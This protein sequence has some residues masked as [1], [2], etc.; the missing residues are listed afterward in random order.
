MRLLR[1]LSILTRHN[2]EAFS[3]VQAGIINDNSVP[4][5][6]SLQIYAFQLRRSINC[7]SNLEKKLNQK[8][9]NADVRH[10]LVIGPGPVHSSQNLILD[11]TSAQLTYPRST[12]LP[13]AISSPYKKAV[14]QPG[15]ESRA[16]ESWSGVNV[17]QW[18]NVWYVVFPRLGYLCLCRNLNCRVPTFL[19]LNYIIAQL[20]YP[21]GIIGS[22]FASV[23]VSTQVCLF[24]LYFTLSL[25][26]QQMATCWPS[27][28]IVLHVLPVTVA[29]ICTS[30]RIIL[31]HRKNHSHSSSS[32]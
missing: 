23:I 25:L 11:S 28:H 19:R 1:N 29:A 14:A 18:C 6:L 31:Y 13:T 15:Y 24:R 20:F 22:C 4:Q 26:S 2:F 9:H 17:W 27:M 8:E 21:S 10:W 32:D 16:H 3:S 30:V 7:E 5:Q 12:S